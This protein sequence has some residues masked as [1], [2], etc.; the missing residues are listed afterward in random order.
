MFWVDS[1]FLNDNKTFRIHPLIK[2]ITKNIEKKG[3]LFIG[4]PW[5]IV[6]WLPTSFLLFAYHLQTELTSKSFIIHSILTCE[7][8]MSVK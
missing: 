2:L 7:K 4:F 3:Y 5:S 6:F 1:C 8:L